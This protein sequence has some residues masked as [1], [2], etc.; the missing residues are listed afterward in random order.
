M[1]FVLVFVNGQGIH[2]FCT[3]IDSEACAEIRN[4]LSAIEDSELVGINEK[5]KL[6]LEFL[7]QLFLSLEYDLS[8]EDQVV[9]LGPV[10]EPVNIRR[11]IHNEE[12]IEVGK[13]MYALNAWNPVNSKIIVCRITEE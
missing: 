8:G 4:I 11:F 10:I 1:S 3:S 7:N 9:S 2:S 5:E 13:S 12:W 6:V